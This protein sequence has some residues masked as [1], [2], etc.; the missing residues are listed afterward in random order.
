VDDAANLGTD[1]LVVLQ[2]G[3]A[4][5]QA[6]IY[7]ATGGCNLYAQVGA[8][9]VTIF[10]DG[11]DVTFP[12]S[13]L[14]NIAGTGVSGPATTGPWNFKVTTDFFI[15]NGPNGGR[16]FSGLV[17]TMPNVGLAPV[18]TA[19]APLP[20][21]PPSGIVSW[22]PG[23][24]N[25]TDIVAGSNGT[26]VGGVTFAPS[27]VGQ[28]FNFN[29]VDGAVTAPH[30]S[31]QN[32]GNQIA[33]E[34]WVY[35]R[36]SGHGRPILQKRSAANVGGYTFETTDTTNGPGPSNGL[37]FVIWINGT[38]NL[39]QTPAN[40]LTIGTWQH[41]A[42]TFDG[43]TMKIYVNGVASASLPVAGTIDPVLNPI[44]IGQNVATTT[45]D[46]DGLI[47]E[48]SLYNRALTAAEIQAIFNAGSAGKLK[49]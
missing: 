43:A 12:L 2:S 5:N 9:P 8:A 11:M 39:L 22:W 24:G 42:A 7:K 36:T 40:A 6:Q 19:S 20:I 10:T 49:P 33:I 31:N 16:N 28:A 41:V 35:P 48:V 30:N 3:F 1:Y 18:P 25:F 47:D 32:T 29:G 21:G 15:G 34:A 23:D 14:T 4:N 44:V 17:D 46:W 13:L 27:E 45:Y 37:Q 26:P 38:Q